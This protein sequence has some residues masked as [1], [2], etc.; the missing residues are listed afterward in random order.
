M[1]WRGSTRERGIGC[2]SG[3]HGLIKQRMNMAEMS[4]SVLKYTSTIYKNI[5]PIILSIII[6]KFIYVHPLFLSEVL[7][8]LFI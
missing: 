2:M 3:S 8:Y 7:S 5:I 4:A 6:T 1:R